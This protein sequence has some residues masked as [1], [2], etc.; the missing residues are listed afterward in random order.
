MV[1]SELVPLAKSGGLADAVAGLARSLGEA[2][3][4]VLVLLPR[5]A[6]IKLHGANS[7]TLLAAEQ[8]LV[9]LHDHDDAF[10]VIL[11]DSPAF[12]E[13]GLYLGDVRDAARFLA[14]AKAGLALPVA[15]GWQ[16]DVV[17]C[18]DWHAALLPALARTRDA[19]PASVL[20]LH[21]IGYQGVFPYAQVAAHPELADLA[22]ADEI[23]FLKAGILTADL[24]ST[25]SPT[26]ATEILT[27]AF[28]MGL[29]AELKL[30]QRD[31]VGILN[32]VDYATWDPANDPYIEH[33][34]EADDPAPKRH[35]KQALL[36][37]S[38]L[39]SSLKIPVIGVVSRLAT[40]K[41][42]DL[43]LES[44]PTLLDATEAAFVVLGSGDPELA[45][46]LQSAAAMWPARMAFTDGY[47]EALAHHILGG[48]DFVL[49]PSRYEP[50]GLTQLYALRYG[51]IPIVRKT[52]GLA[53]TIQHF[54]PETG[55][56]NG[57]VFEH[58]DAPGLIW[59]TT[60]ALS[61]Y[62][63]AASWTRITRNAMTA[64]H[65]WA[66]RVGDYEALYQRAVSRHTT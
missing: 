5:Y 14:L 3:H 29:D 59:A 18:H 58:A 9:E 64:D 21:N 12:S 23:N 66:A 10:R 40:Q 17:H 1:C 39:A 57:S 63:D 7:E 26:Y 2:G 45:A 43:I 46:A 6:H 54:D 15:L 33:H 13:P 62:R 52:G 53:D 47:D 24:I 35:L 50:C 34:Y 44:L 51:S 49:V 38:G 8:R 28:G 36:T 32:G 20:T 4:E 27:A 42:I 30:R 56:G 19:S 31:V 60:T 16:P 22:E 11:L 37:K 41:G 48:A 65:S 25:V 55:A 61:W